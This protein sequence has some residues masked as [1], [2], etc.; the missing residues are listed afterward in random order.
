[1]T[2]YNIMPARL[3]EQERAGVFIFST[4]IGDIGCAFSESM[5]DFAEKYRRF[6]DGRD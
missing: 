1:M 6:T 3:S 5:L 2:K 4:T